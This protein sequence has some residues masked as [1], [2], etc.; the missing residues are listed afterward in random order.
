MKPP[1]G[2]SLTLASAQFVR[3]LINNNQGNRDA[4]LPSHLLQQ[5]P[6]PSDRFHHRKEERRGCE[7]VEHSNGI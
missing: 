7:I 4:R 2:I 1:I 5:P 6:R 3:A